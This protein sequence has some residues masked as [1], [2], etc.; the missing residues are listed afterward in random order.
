MN[1]PLWNTV[2]QLILERP[3]GTTAVVLRFLT[4]AFRVIDSSLPNGRVQ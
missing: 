1:L 2:Q 3:G 4:M